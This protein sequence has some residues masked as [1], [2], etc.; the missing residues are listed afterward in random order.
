MKDDTKVKYKDGDWL[1]HVYAGFV[2]PAIFN[3]YVGRDSAVVQLS[4]DCKADISVSRLY[5]D[6]D[7]LLAL[8]RD[9]I[10]QEIEEYA[11]GM[12]EVAAH[13]IRAKSY[14]EGREIAIDIKPLNE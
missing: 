4:Y 3:H 7:E 14:F 11:Q 2:D 6:T 12:F 9:K 1:Y 8:L 5:H 10:I 13:Y